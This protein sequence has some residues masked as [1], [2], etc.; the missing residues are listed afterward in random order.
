MRQI[1]AVILI[2]LC[3]Y[4]AN[5]EAL[6]GLHTGANLGGA[7]LEPDNGADFSRLPGAAIGIFIEHSIRESKHFFFHGEFGYVEK[8]WKSEGV[9]SFGT[10]YQSETRT[11]EF[12]VAPSIIARILPEGVTPFVELG[13]ELGFVNSKESKGEVAE[14]TLIDDM[15]YYADGNYGFNMGGGLLIPLAKG[16]F[17]L[18]IR[19]NRGLKD[20]DESDSDYVVKTSGVQFLGGYRFMI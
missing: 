13:L 6:L 4:S 9:I 16:Q 7:T 14:F 5:A 18:C 8:N 1:L 15:D 20:M 19:L 12:V 10:A 11:S 3:S 2:G 17:E